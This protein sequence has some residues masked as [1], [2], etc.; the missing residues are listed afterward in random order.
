MMLPVI[1]MPPYEFFSVFD[2]TIP[3]ATTTG[4]FLWMESFEQ[5]SFAT[6]EMCRCIKIYNVDDD[7]NGNNND[8]GT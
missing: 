2:G 5:S 7:D 6:F 8:T 1:M 3:V 4:G